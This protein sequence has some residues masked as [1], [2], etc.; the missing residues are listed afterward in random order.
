[1][2]N[3]RQKNKQTNKLKKIYIFNILWLDKHLGPYGAHQV[4]H[5]LKLGPDQAHQVQL[6]Q[7]RSANKFNQFWQGRHLGPYGAHQVWQDLN[8]GLTKLTKFNYQQTNYMIGL[9]PWQLFETL[10]DVLIDWENRTFPL[11]VWLHTSTKWLNFSWMFQHRSC[12]E[13]ICHGS[14][15]ILH[16]KQTNKQ[17]NKFSNLWN[18]KELITWFTG[19]S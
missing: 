9:S 8:L 5:D 15:L 12:Y 10:R 2:K 13:L 1:M 17:T 7:T 16:H 18:H 19:R 11:Y 6:W 4:W 14:A 3:K